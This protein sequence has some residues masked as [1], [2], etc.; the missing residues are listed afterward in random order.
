M[1]YIPSGDDALSTLAGATLASDVQ[2]GVSYRIGE[3]LGGGAMAVAF[4]AV[5]HAGGGQSSVVLKILRPTLA[6]EAAGMAALAV[7]KEAVALGRLNERVP[8]TP[9]V[10]RLVDTGTLVAHDGVHRLE[11]PWLAIEHVSGGAEGT[12]LDERVL[13]SL[14]HTRYAFEP[15]R[16]AGAVVCLTAGVAAIHEVGVLH[17]DLKPSNVL[18]CGSGAE[19]ILKIADFGIA[20]PGGMIATFSGAALG[21]PGYAA[22][23]QFGRDPARVGPWSDVFGLAAILYHLLTGEEYFPTDSPGESIVL[24]HR[25]ERRWLADARGL[26]PLLRARPAVCATLDAALARATAVNPDHRPQSADVL[27]AMVVPAL[28]ACGAGHRTVDRRARSLAGRAP[29][30]P[31]GEVTWTPRR[32]GGGTAV[33]R[34]VA[35][36][37]DLTCLCATS[38]GVAFWSGT[39]FVLAPP[40][41]LPR[42]EHI[43]FVRRMGADAWLLGGEGA[44]VFRYGAE[45]V[46]PLLVGRDPAVR[47]VLASG[48]VDELAVFVGVKEGEAPTLHGVAAGHWMKPAALPRAASITSLSQLDEER[49]LVT[50]RATGR[51]DA[52]GEGFAV[53]YEPLMWEVKRLKTPAVRVYLATATRPEL[54]LGVIGGSGGQIM[55]FHGD[56]LTPVRLPGD[57]AISAVALDP[58]G[59]AWAA[60]MGSLWTA[61]PDEP[62]TWRCVW[63]DEAAS[64]PVISLHADLGGV[65]AMTANGG[66]LEGRLA[67]AR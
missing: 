28:R 27:A 11:L 52:P 54:G 35:W 44:A 66:I 3:V 38:E 5:R 15:E 47:F 64:A 53:V 14:R 30:A 24:A 65:I 41:G 20:R 25:V 29:T 48:D 17:R 46:S 34:S 10:V 9:Y 56:A 18:C 7:Q 42:P 43:H 26:C 4:S 49:W 16:A 37:G 21:T 23:E 39:R 51:E 61:E 45:G 8:P 40:A 13:H 1:F 60:S 58:E 55:H 67:R 57:P 36:A 33:V 63:R 2:P 62:T 59:R 12:T 6:R 19:E 31:G 22:P 50:G 32:P